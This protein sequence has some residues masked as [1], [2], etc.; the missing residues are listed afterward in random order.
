MCTSGLIGTF[1]GIKIGTSRFPIFTIPL[2]GSIIV[3]TSSVGTKLERIFYSYHLQRKNAL[4][5]GRNSLQSIF[6]LIGC[7][8]SISGQKN[9]RPNSSE[10]DIHLLFP[11]LT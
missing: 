3:Y 1:K 11:T 10:R 2:A 4:S 9:Y 8:F 7:L 5:G 6:V